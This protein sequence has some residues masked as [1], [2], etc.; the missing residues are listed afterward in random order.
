MEKTCTKCGTTKPL[1]QFY[2]VKRV[3]PK[4]RNVPHDDHKS[5][6]KACYSVKAKEWAEANR[7]KRKTIADRWATENREKIKESSKKQR[8]KPE[9]KERMKSWRLENTTAYL[10]KRRQEDQ[11]FALKIKMRSI[12][13]KALYR[14]GYT[15][16]STSNEILGCSWEEL[17]NHLERQFQPGMTWENRGQWHIDHIVPLA[18]AQTEEDVIR[19]NHH[20][21]LQPLW[22]EDNLKKSDKATFLI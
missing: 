1:D 16:R 13:L 5:Q 2:K 4:V 8:K 3:S 21:N 14:N 6:C 9:Y 22:A 11:M 18:T 10:R 7:E 20:T 19:L 12:I 17:K 15:K